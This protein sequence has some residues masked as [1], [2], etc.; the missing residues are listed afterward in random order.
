MDLGLA[1]IG[2]VGLLLLPLLVSRAHQRPH[3]PAALSAWLRSASQSPHL[4][5]HHSDS[6]QS[7][8]EMQCFD[9]LFL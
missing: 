9:L 1:A 7:A 6:L 5:G 8:G 2:L 4:Q 3:A